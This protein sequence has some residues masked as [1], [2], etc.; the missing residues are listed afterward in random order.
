VIRSGIQNVKNVHWLGVRSHTQLPQYLKYFDVATI[1]F[2]LNKITHSTSPV[3]LFEYMAGGKPVVTTAMHESSRCEGVIVTESPE[4]FVRKLDEAL[5][6]RTD[7]VYLDLIDR[8]ARENTWDVRA[9]QILEA[10]TPRKAETRGSLQNAPG[11]WQKEAK[12]DSAVTLACEADTEAAPLNQES[13]ERVSAPVSPVSQNSKFF[14]LLGERSHFERL[15]EINHPTK[16]MWVEFALST[17]ERGQAVVNEVK[18]YTR[19]RGKKFLDVGCAY[20]GFLVA[21]AAKGASQVIGIDINSDLL[22]LAAA[23][24]E[25]CQVSASLF[26]RDLLDPGILE[27]GRFDIISCNDVIEHV[28]DPQKAL[29]RLSLLL[30][31]GGVLYMEIP[32]KYFVGFLKADGHYQLP[33]ITLLPR[34]KAARY[35]FLNF[36]DGYGVEFYRKLDYY[37]LHLTKQGLSPILLNKEPGRFDP[38]ALDGMFQEALRSFDSFQGKQ[39]E[40]ALAEEIRAKGKRLYEIFTREVQAYQVFL[41][42]DP[43]RARDLARRIHLRYGVDFWRVLARK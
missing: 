40:P 33:G 3:K 25:D 26:Q 35:H 19:I 41:G 34:Q 36:G 1:P 22:Q 13:E 38:Q 17:N 2:K 28:K 39:I 24:L 29:A 23:N 6:R 4:D 9:Q 10:L 15:E 5:Q 37:L 7:P 8:L 43:K 11:S 16:R 21:F 12:C 27:L 20:G 18:R 31:A 14:K 30:E 32:N 42:Q